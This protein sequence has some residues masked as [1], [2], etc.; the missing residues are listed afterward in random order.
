M[1]RKFWETSVAHEP[2]FPKGKEK[3][4]EEDSLGLPKLIPPSPASASSHTHPD[5]VSATGN[6][7]I[8]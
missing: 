5:P 4:R 7:S 2:N 3:A 6:L 1:D 8:N